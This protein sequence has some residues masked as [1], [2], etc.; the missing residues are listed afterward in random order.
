MPPSPCMNY[1]GHRE[2]MMIRP[3]VWLCGLMTGMGA[4]LLAAEPLPTFEHEIRPLLKVHCFRCHGEDEPLS[5]GLDL[6]LVRLQRIGGDSGPAVVSGQPEKSL[7]LTRIKA[8]EMP[9]EGAA[10]L[11]PSQIALLEQWIASGAPTLR[12]E[13]ASA[14]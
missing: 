6:R 13:P 4:A 3:F 2:T 1:A 14:E 10:P 7:L 9:P 11:K 5:G 8:G 12:P